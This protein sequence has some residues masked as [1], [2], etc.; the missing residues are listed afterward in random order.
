MAQAQGDVRKSRI[1]M[2][3][4]GISGIPLDILIP[5]SEIAKS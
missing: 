3:L 1:N 5:L 2:T 4:R